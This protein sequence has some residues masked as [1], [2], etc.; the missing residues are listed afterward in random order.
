M[1]KLIFVFLMLFCL[2]GCDN[3]VEFDFNED[4]KAKV[5]LSF[6]IDEYKE[7]IN[8][9]N[10][11]DEEARSIIESMIEFRNAF[12]DPY[13]ELFEEK[14]FMNNGKYYEGLFEKNDMYQHTI[15]SRTMKS[16]DSYKRLKQMIQI[17]ID[18]FSKFSKDI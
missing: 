16:G 17:N 13:S 4:I 8:E 11:D 9:E 12:T 3:S 2:T 5:S 10:L 15:L 18:A 1:K 7:R 14:S 6:T